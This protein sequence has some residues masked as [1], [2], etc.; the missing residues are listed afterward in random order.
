MYCMVFLTHYFLG[1]GDLDHQKTSCWRWVKSQIY[2]ACHSTWSC[3]FHRQDTH[4][5]PP[6][7]VAECLS[8]RLPGDAEK[9]CYPLVFLLDTLFKGHIAFR[10]Q[11]QNKRLIS[12]ASRQLVGA[13]KAIAFD[14]FGYFAPCLKT[15]HNHLEHVMCRNTHTDYSTSFCWSIANM[16]RMYQI[17]CAEYDAGL[18][19]TLE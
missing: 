6:Q 2:L 17:V 12:R 14:A 19:S 7:E 16:D 3:I 1:A 9:I 8:V 10:R 13:S 5:E 15:C 11:L 18:V 4:Q